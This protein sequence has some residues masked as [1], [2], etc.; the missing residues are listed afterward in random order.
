M[1][2]VVGL[3][4][5]GDSYEQTRHNI[6]FVVL[7]KL[8][9]ELS[10]KSPE[11]SAEDK[12]RAWVVKEGGVI[13]A[14]PVTFMNNSGEAVGS[15]AS[16]YKIAPEDIIVVHDDIDLPLGKIRIRQQGGT[17][18][19]NGVNS[20]LSHLKS[21]KFTRVRLGVGSGKSEHH[22]VADSHTRHQHVIDYVLSRFGSNEAG[23]MRKLVEHG[24]EAV[25]M[26]LTDGIDKAMN[27]FN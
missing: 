13:L 5:P 3:G 12:H 22:K 20:V 25:R 27:R 8:R 14:K 19:H 17:G 15:L 4:N 11:W 9:R 18:G 10:D 2:L 7:D 6:G 1:K 26:I 23:D 21:D 24:V 16:F